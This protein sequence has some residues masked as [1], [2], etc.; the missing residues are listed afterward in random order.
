[1]AMTQPVMAF[2]NPKAIG[3]DCA[4]RTDAVVAGH[5]PEID[6]RHAPSNADC[7]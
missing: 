6:D 3:N 4:A 7:T 5:E 1:M 2:D